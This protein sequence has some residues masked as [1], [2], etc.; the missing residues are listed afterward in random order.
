MRYLT[1]LAAFG[2]CLLANVA[3]HAGAPAAATAIGS[4]PAGLSASS[5]ATTDYNLPQ[6]GVAGGTVLPLW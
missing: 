4:A 6:L 2:C 3:A 5:A 1:A